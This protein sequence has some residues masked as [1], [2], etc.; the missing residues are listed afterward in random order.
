MDANCF[1]NASNKSSIN[2]WPQLNDRDRHEA[3]FIPE[4][5][6]QNRSKLET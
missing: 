4:K 2:N 3:N 6:Q 5:P 1:L